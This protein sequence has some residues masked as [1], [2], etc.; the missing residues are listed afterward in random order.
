MVSLLNMI[1]GFFA[2]KPKRTYVEV[3]TPAESELVKLHLLAKMGKMF[4]LAL[5]FGGCA[6]QKGL[7]NRGV[8]RVCTAGVCF[9]RASADIVDRRCKKGMTKWD[10]GETDIS[11]RRARCCAIYS[12]GRKRFRIWVANGEEECIVHEFCHVDQ[13]LSSRPDHSKCHNFGLGKE[14]KTIGG[15]AYNPETE[16]AQ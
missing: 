12:R 5:L 14:K 2:P 11:A 13:Y 10:D 6:S 1:S 9:M 4:A 8:E 15:S 3:N 7:F 16:W